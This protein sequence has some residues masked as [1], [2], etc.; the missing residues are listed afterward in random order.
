MATHQFP[1]IHKTLEATQQI[2]LD[3][4]L[5][6]PVATMSDE[7]IAAIG[8]A[9][10]QLSLQCTLLGKGKSKL[11]AQPGTEL[12]DPD[13]MVHDELEQIKDHMRSLRRAILHAQDE[14]AKFLRSARLARALQKLQQQVAQGYAA[15]T[16]LQWE[17]GEQDANNA[18]RHGPLIASNREELNK[19]LEQ[20][21]STK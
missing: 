2:K 9:T 6:Q 16:E 14:N 20:I 3:Q 4:L 15:A 13:L 18:P 1:S 12:L 17:I 8:E 7:T 10:R 21:G 5:Q 11:T 19:I